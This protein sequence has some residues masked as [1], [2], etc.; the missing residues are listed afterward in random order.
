MTTVLLPLDGTTSS[1][2]AIPF[3]QLLA[4]RLFADLVLVRSSWNSSEDEVSAYLDGVLDR[5]DL[6][7]DTVGRVVYRFPGDALHDLATDYDDSAICLYSHGRSGLGHFLLGSYSESILALS[8][9]PVFAVGPAARPGW[10]AGGRL[11]V[12]V[13]ASTDPAAIAPFAASW[14]TRLGLGADV[15]TVRPEDERP[16]TRFHPATR[17]LLNDLVDRLED[18]GTH[19][20]DFVLKEVQPA[21]RLARFA[22]EHDL[23]LLVAAKR[24]DGAARDLLGS[25]TMNLIHQ[26]PCPVL[27]PPI[28]TAGDERPIARDTAGSNT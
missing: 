2:Q 10:P 21:R 7:L 28:P 16:V 8:Q 6:D 14:A 23:A 19:A 24:H 27:V 17:V 20:R 26:S 11:G 3:G 1:E 22:A 5:Y 18:G 25:T 4:L 12:C 15:L 9:V 13:D